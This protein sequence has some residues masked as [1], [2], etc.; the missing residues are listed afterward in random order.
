M[1]V[2]ND[3]VALSSIA[4]VPGTGSEAIQKCQVLVRSKV[5]NI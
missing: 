1:R 5:Y 4:N 3:K 2:D